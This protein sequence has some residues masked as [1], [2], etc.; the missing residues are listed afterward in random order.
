MKRV[1]PFP[2]AH[3]TK[4]N[5]L[6]VKRVVE[7]GMSQ[8]AVAR[9][10]HLTPT[11]V[12]EIVRVALGLRERKPLNVAVHARKLAASKRKPPPLTTRRR[13]RL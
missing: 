7:D 6:I 10:F 2:R 5:A 11:S 13:A 4:R 12:C 3:V 8:A 1:R 9:R